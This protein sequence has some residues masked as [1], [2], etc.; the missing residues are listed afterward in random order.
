M[1][2]IIIVNKIFAQIFSVRKIHCSNLEVFNE[3]EIVTMKFKSNYLARVRNGPKLKTVTVQMSMRRGWL[4]GCPGIATLL[5]SW[6][7]WPIFP[8]IFVKYRCY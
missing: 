2:L 5:Q 6:R 8:Q 1:Q 3:I 7:N 4:G